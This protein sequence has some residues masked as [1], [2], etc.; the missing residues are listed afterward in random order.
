MDNNK[1]PILAI[2]QSLSFLT[3][4]IDVN[5]RVDLQLQN[6]MQDEKKR[7]KRVKPMQAEQEARERANQIQ[8]EELAR[9]QAE[10]QQTVQLA[11]TQ[12]ARQQK[13]KELFITWKA[14]A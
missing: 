3:V 11:Q 5:T 2:F 9:F 13:R 14:Q 6:E 1:T 8:A 12:V 10:A 7:R 4:E